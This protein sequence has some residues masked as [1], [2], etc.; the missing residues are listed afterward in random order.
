MYTRGNF[1][2]TI[3]LNISPC[4]FQNIPCFK[5][6]LYFL[7][8]YSCQVFQEGDKCILLSVLCIKVSVRKLM[9]TYF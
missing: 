3:A 9:F 5:Q 8:T 1:D 7:V 4:P 6:G 2:V